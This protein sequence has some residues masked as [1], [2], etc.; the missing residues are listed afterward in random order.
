MIEGFKTQAQAEAFIKWYEGQGEQDAVIWFECRM[1]EG[2]IDV[3]SMNVDCKKTY[4]LQ[5]KDD[6]VKMVVKPK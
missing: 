5:W 2:Q 4:P 1:Q 6:V 3:D